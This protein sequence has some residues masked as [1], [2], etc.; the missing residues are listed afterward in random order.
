MG[1]DADRRLIHH[2]IIFH[3]DNDRVRAFFQTLPCARKGCGVSQSSSRAIWDSASSAAVGKGIPKGGE[4]YPIT[5]RFIR[6]GNPMGSVAYW[7]R[8]KLGNY[9]TTTERQGEML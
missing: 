1:G 3:Y 6:R 7:Q 8:R 2:D 5:N 4:N 9:R